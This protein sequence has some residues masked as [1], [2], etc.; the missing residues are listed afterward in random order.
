MNQLWADLKQIPGPCPRLIEQTLLS[1]EFLT[2]VP[3]DSDGQVGLG[4][5]RLDDCPKV[6]TKND[7]LSVS[8]RLAKLLGRGDGSFD[9]VTLPL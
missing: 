3:G 4:P 2:S 5:F 7:H 8:Y 1:N 6:F 9:W